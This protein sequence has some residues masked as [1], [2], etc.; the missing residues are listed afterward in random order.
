[1][2]KTWY[3]LVG[4]WMLVGCKHEF[5][6]TT[7]GQAPR[8]SF[9]SFELKPNTFAQTNDTLY[10]LSTDTLQ[11]RLQGSDDTEVSLLKLEIRNVYIPSPTVGTEL[12]QWEGVVKIKQ[13]EFSLD[14]NLP[15]IASGAFSGTYV[16]KA[17]LADVYGTISETSSKYIVVRNAAEIPST[18]EPG[19]T[20]KPGNPLDTLIVSASIT[21]LPYVSGGSMEF[22]I[23]SWP[24]STL[25]SNYYRENDTSKAVIKSTNSIRILD[26]IYFSNSLAPDSL[27]FSLLY[28]DQ[29]GLK[30][31]SRRGTYGLKKAAK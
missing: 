19:F 20:F 11:V 23:I 15:I 29:L 22:R 9:L 6:S 1:M 5:E 13:K 25:Y 12:W 24:D 27:A 8:V 10:A 3:V 4:L 31:P 7:D 16:L 17:S 18:S 2:R 21:D 30:A 14:L 28:T 26:T